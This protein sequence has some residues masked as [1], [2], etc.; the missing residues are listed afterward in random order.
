MHSVISR[1]KS[2]NTLNCSIRAVY[3]KLILFV[4]FVASSATVSA[5]EVGFLPATVDLQVGEKALVHVV[6]TGVPEPGLQAFQFRVEFNTG[7][8]NLNNPNFATPFAAFEPLGGKPFCSIVTSRDACSD[9]AWFLI[10]TG[11]TA[12]LANAAIDNGSGTGQIAYGSSGTESA[13]V[14][15]GAIAI[16]E[17]E[18]IADGVVQVNLTDIVLARPDL[19]PF[20]VTFRNLTINVGTTPNNSNPRAVN[21]TDVATEDTAITVTVLANDSDVDGDVL[22]VSSTT[23]GANGSVS[24]NA[25]NTLTYTPNVNFHGVDSFTYTISDGNGGAAT[26]TVSVTVT[27]VNDMPIATDDTANLPEDSAATITVLANDSDVDGDTLSVSSTT[28]GTNGSVA[29]NADGTLTYTPNANFNGADSFTYTVSDGNGGSDTAIVNISVGASNDAP[30]ATD[31]SANTQEDTAVTIAVL[32]N[33]SDIEGDTLRIA[34]TTQGTN[35]SVTVNGGNVLTYTPNANF[36]GVD[37]FGYTIIDGNGGSDIASVT[38]SVAPINDAP[39]AADDSADTQ[40]DTA[41][42][43]NVLANDSDIDSDT[44]SVLSTTP[45]ANGSV[46]INSDNSLTYSPNGNFNG[47]DSFTY[48]VSDGDSS[49]DTATV[50]VTVTSV[51]DAPVAINDSV[52]TQEDTSVTVIVLAN[53]SDEEGDTLTVS[54]T[55]QGSNGSVNINADYSVTYTPNVN[56]NGVDNFTYTVSDG[57]S[58]TDTATVTVSVSPVN[59]APVAINDSANTLED[60]SVTVIVLANDSDVDG[61][62][63]NVS[64]ATQGINGVVS[65][66]AD[67]TVTYIPN[68]NFNGVDNFTYTINDSNS[69]SD[70]ANVTINI[71]GT[72][73]A[74][75]AL[76]DTVSTPEDMAVTIEVLANDSDQDGDTLSVL[77]T[78]QGANG[79]VDINADNTVT[80]T[81]NANYNGVDSFIYT[82]S[83]G[84]VSDFATV[85]IIVTPVND[86]PVAIDDSAN[87]QEDTEVTVTALANDIDVDNDTLIVATVTQGSNGSVTINADNTLT[88]TPNANFNGADSFSYAINDGNIVSAA[89]TVSIN[90][91]P[92]ND[93]PIAI[94]DSASTLEDTAVNIDVLSNDSDVDNDTL[95]VS[96]VTQGSNGA[97]VINADNTI[98]YAPD[99]NFVGGDTFTYTI[100]DSNGGVDTATVTINVGGLNDVPIAIDDSAGTQEDTAITI[101]VLVNDSDPDDDVLILLS[102]T[103]GSNGSVNINIDNTVTYVP[104]ANFNGV[105]TFTYTIG[106]GNGGSDT[107]NVDININAIN[108]APVANAGNDVNVEVGTPAV[109]DGSASFDID[110]DPLNFSW[111]FSILPVGSILTNGDLVGIN[112]PSVMFTPDVLGDYHVELTVF[113]GLLGTTDVAVVMAANPPNISPNA[114]AGADQ[115]AQTGTVVVLDASASNDPDNGP[116]AMTFSWFFNSVPVGSALTNANIANVNGVVA[117]FTPDADGGYSLTLEV[118]DGEAT[119][120]DQVLITALTPPNVP[121]NADAGSDQNVNAD[122]IVNLDGSSSNDP[123]GGPDILSFGWTFVSIPTTSGLT[124]IDIIDSN[125]VLPSFAPDVVGTYL[126]RLDVFDGDASDFDQI[127]VEVIQLGSAPLAPTDLVGRSKLLHVNLNWA[128]TDGASNYRV[129]RR[130]DSETNFVEIAQ[131]PVS[132]LVDDFPVGTSS[133]EYFLV[134]EN[135]FGVSPDSEIIVVRTSTRAR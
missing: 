20:P 68:A 36:N 88:Y 45:G 114:L 54:S 82:I 35:G 6:V 80:Y 127:M 119:N 75:I 110:G 122:T 47:V 121:P 117:T 118:S 95:L 115:T 33:D 92:I 113:D 131:V 3:N 104:N 83:D 73:D 102:S 27:P 93:V 22:T 66:N 8:A 2:N 123:D 109:L 126:I 29:T 86:A 84:R 11:R 1:E 15:S 46:V 132:A 69:A 116:Q 85:S 31:D 81:P 5:A 59:D 128:A 101:D 40:E 98:V 62:T 125:T 50:S 25:D 63:L 61:D 19:Q 32:S 17:V 16:I 103:Q 58:G 60:I 130:L 71:G 64:S 51:N 99:N 41:I 21:D 107:A 67:N 23:Q 108:D 30:V 10:S 42:T 78:T 70:T 133:A 7:L 91:T 124:N 13:S 24:V 26:A 57:N 28:Q 79:T 44:L 34:S 37:S 74:P 39:T 43:I 77:S 52:I 9:P 100:N 87:T 106:D 12:Q 134:A 56:F 90:V 4:L 14:G 18:G 65:I 48:I 89:A 53:D 129:F 97:V 96:S 55:T 135:N 94:D 120:Q 72:N 112:T 105:D 49:N 76:D 111:Q 38:V